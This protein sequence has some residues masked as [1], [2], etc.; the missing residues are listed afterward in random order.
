MKAISVL[1]GKATLNRLLTHPVRG[2]ENFDELFKTLTGPNGAIKVCC[3][4]DE[5]L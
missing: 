5:M 3:E 4:A 2:L 1:P